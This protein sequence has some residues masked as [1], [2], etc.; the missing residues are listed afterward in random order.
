[1]VSVE[2]LMSA[3]Y[4]RIRYLVLVALAAGTTACVTPPEQDPTVQRLTE[5]DGRLLRIERVISNQSLLDISQRNDALQNE[6]R[7]VRGQ[8]EETQHALEAS[9]NQQREMYGDLD[10]RLQ[11]IEA[12]GAAAATAGVAARASSGASDGGDRAAY[13]VAFDQLKDGK[14][15][16][17]V[18]GFS[19]F[20]VTYPQS[21]LVDN[22][23][24][25]LGEAHYV[26]KDYPQALR[27]FQTVLQK[28]P[29]SRKV[30]DALLKVGYCQYELKN[31]R[32]A[33][34]VLNK[35]VQQY[36]ETSSARLAQQRIAKLDGE[37]R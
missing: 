13:Q 37:G 5:I 7:T 18:N 1:M 36:P 8:L 10:R 16:E 33:R 25:W 4:R 17:A 35:L 27:D 9:R 19:N 12:G 34:E 3:R 20:L 11:A 14:Y 21:T 29:D 22:A 23:Q 24:Y 6:L 2:E 32:D 15:P 30:P 31:F 28:Y 26:L